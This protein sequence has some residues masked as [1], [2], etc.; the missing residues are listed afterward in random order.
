M[1]PTCRVTGRTVACVMIRR[2]HAAA[3]AARPERTCPFTITAAGK[4]GDRTRKPRGLR[5]LR[6]ASSYHGCRYGGYAR[7][8]CGVPDH[9]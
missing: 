1:W 3:A 9:P 5:A 8:A 4:R 6:R 2:M 7:E